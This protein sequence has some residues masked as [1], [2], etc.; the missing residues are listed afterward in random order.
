MWSKSPDRVKPRLFRAIVRFTLI[1]QEGQSWRSRRA[2]IQVSAVADEPAQRDASRQTCCNQRC[3]KLATELSY[4]QRFRT[5]TFSSY[6][7]WFVESRH[8][9]LPHLHLASPLGVTSFEFCWSLWCQKTRVP[10]L[11]CS[12]VCVILPL[13]V[14][15]QHPLVTDE[16]TDR[17]A[18][19]RLRHIPR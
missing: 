12:T 11:L 13:A 14:S 18:D 19:T 2:I 3:D 9:N 6:N 16:R 8:F 7:E 15:V 4:H 1:L 17:Q 10:G 5:S